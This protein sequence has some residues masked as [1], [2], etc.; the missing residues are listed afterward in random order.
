[1]SSD[2]SCFR[3]V[4]L[5]ASS[6][7]RDTRQSER[8][9][10]RS[11]F[12]TQHARGSH[13]TVAVVRRRNQPRP[14]LQLWRWGL[15]EAA[16]PQKSFVTSKSSW[17]HR[18]CHFLLQQTKTRKKNTFYHFQNKVEINGLFTRASDGVYSYSKCYTHTHWNSCIQLAAEEIGLFDSKSR[19]SSSC[20]LKQ[21]LLFLL[22]F[23]FFAILLVSR[24]CRGHQQNHL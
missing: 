13:A 11:A 2:C 21:C 17:F 22:S 18:V 9:A 12:P 7:Q 6:K 4:G 1:M 5:E 20:I 10:E 24:N 3:L 8:H 14:G 23:V 15:W 19:F 16:M